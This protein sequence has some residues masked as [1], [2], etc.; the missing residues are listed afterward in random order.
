MVITYIHTEDHDNRT[1]IMKYAM[2]YDAYN[3][4]FYNAAQYQYRSECSFGWISQKFPCPNAN[5]DMNEF[6]IAVSSWLI[7]MYGKY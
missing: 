1:P 3:G 6:A 5:S 2:L 4:T 7:L